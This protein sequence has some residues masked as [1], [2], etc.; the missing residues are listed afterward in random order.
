M[1]PRNSAN[2]F[3]AMGNMKILILLLALLK[4]VEPLN[5]SVSRLGFLKSSCGFMLSPSI[6]SSITSPT[7]PASLTNV[8]TN[9]QFTAQLPL[10]NA[11]NHI[12]TSVDTHVTNHVI[13]GSS[14]LL[15]KGNQCECDVQLSC[16]TVTY[17]CDV[18]L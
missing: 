14:I 3:G 5:L 8:L 7:Q 17:N 1:R 11:Y 18:Q 10:I 16:T 9:D 6:T 2:K 15:S 12:T 13:Y 4:P